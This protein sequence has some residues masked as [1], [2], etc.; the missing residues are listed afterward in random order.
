[1][2]KRV[3]YLTDAELEIMRMLW[4]SEKP[5][6]S[7]MIQKGL[8]YREW[9]LSTLMGALKRLESKGYIKR[10]GSGYRIMYSSN[11]SESQYLAKVFANMHDVHN[12]LHIKP[13]EI[14][15]SLYENNILSIEHIKEILMCMENI[16]KNSK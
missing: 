11:I 15:E 4:D 14:I 1:M 3:R 9:K 5:M 7:T 13:G 10:D 2:A 8:T 12:I 6:D 16:M